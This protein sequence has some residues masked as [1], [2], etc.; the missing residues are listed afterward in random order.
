MAVE[1]SIPASV[2]P[3]VCP[4]PHGMTIDASVVSMSHE[5]IIASA[6]APVPVSVPAPARVHAAVV[7]SVTQ[8]VVDSSDSQLVDIFENLNEVDGDGVSGEVDY[9]A[10]AD[11]VERW[12]AEEEALRDN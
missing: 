8:E 6:S 5:D 12:L 11:E 10:L 1:P 3:G 9:M 7:P 4:F 2:A